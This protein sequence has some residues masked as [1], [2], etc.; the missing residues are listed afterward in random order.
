M[1]RTI[2][3]LIICFLCIA[4]NAQKVAIVVGN[5]SYNPGP[6]GNLQT[7]ENDARL[8]GEKLKSLGFQVYPIIMIDAT[9]ENILSV[10]N[11]FD[12]DFSK[13]D[14]GVFY[15]SGHGTNYGT[16]TYLVPSKTDLHEITLC[17]EC[18]SVDAISNTFSKKCELSFLIID[19]CRDELIQSKGTY[20]GAS[21]YLPQIDI[22][23]SKTTIV[24]NNKGD[25]NNQQKPKGQMILYA[26][27]NGN[28][29]DS[30]SGPISIFTSIFCKHISE[31]KN[32]T[33][34]WAT[35]KDEVKAYTNNS[36][37]PDNTGS[38]ENYFS[39]GDNTPTITNQFVY[40]SFNVTPNNAK[41]YFGDS[42][43]ELN[44]PL[45]FE[46]GK[47]YTYRIEADGYE[48]KI[49]RIVITENMTPYKMITLKRASV[50]TTQSLHSV[51]DVLSKYYL[52]GT[53]KVS[54]NGNKSPSPYRV[55]NKVWF[56]DYDDDGQNSINYHYS[57]N[58]ELGV[59]YM[60]R[61]EDSR[62]SLGG[63]IATSFGLYK[64]WEF[65]PSS[66]DVSTSTSVTISD[67]QYEYKS[68]SVDGTNNKY[69]ALVDPYNEAKHYDSDALFLV[70]AGFNVCNGFIIE[71]GAGLGYHRDKYK[72]NNTYKITKTDVYDLQ[73][74]NLVRTDYEY[75]QTN[76]SH[77]YKQN[78][79]F[80]PAIRIGGKFYIPL[81]DYTD[82]GALLL[83][84][85]YTY[86]PCNKKRNT[87][88][89]TI[90][91]NWCF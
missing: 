25:Y 55:T 15:F 70:N 60:Y 84:G 74:N 18:V 2:I 82:N 34:V 71:A 65:W 8:M 43:Y 86:Q 7:P 67:N 83:G 5:K 45:Q 90:G 13:V 6:F 85:G 59:S 32:F 29:T 16:K 21:S 19:A 73:T 54:S 79:K 46:V 9:R 81:V 87:W 27:K 22:T 57:P 63:M 39:F 17:D 62:F 41:L 80:S 91:Y 35:I 50:N 47:T 61:F 4:V 33:S 1:R 66:I 88:D 72:M 20:K 49:E 78:S 44:K 48:T 53:K 52:D 77:W 51:K 10:L 89:I 68:S 36:L 23:Q 11:K 12:K 64:G 3:L 42:Q 56:F 30:G 38:Y 40:I 75:E 26:T 14:V 24:S 58:D 28:K 76:K 37:I 31:N 69:S